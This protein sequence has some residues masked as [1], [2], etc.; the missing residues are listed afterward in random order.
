MK[1][2]NRHHKTFKTSTELIWIKFHL[3]QAEARTQIVNI[4][5]LKC[6]QPKAQPN[7]SV[8]AKVVKK[9]NKSTTREGPI[10][11][12]SWL[13]A[14]VVPPNQKSQP[15]LS[16]QTLGLTFALKLIEFDWP[17]MMLSKGGNQKAYF[18][19]TIFLIRYRYS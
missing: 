19:R 1:E 11:S 9:V 5:H 12:S 13:A 17:S 2:K 8:C 3:F 18:S 14:H 7:W 4:L 15:I 10:E 16:K 6:N